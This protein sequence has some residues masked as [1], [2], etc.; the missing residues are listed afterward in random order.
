[1]KHFNTLLVFVLV[2]LVSGIQAQNRFLEEVFDDIT[3]TENVVY[4]ENISIITIPITGSPLKQP[5][6]M[7]I[8]E[9]V[10]DELDERPVILMFH[11][12]NFI[13][14]PD[15]QGTGG[16]I[17]DSTLVNI[18]RRLTR[19]GY[20]VAS[21]DYRKGWN[22]IADQQ[23][24]RV[25][26]L[27]NAAYR[28]VQDARTAIRYVKRSAEEF[29]NPYRFDPE[30]ITLWG[31]GTGGYISLNTTVLDDY[32]KVLI[33][34]FFDEGPDGNPIPMVIQPIHGDIYGTSVGLNPLTGD[35]LSLPNHVGYDSDFHLSV[36]M[37][38]AM[39][40]TSW[41]DPGMIPMI[42]YQVPTDPFAPYVEAV[43]IVPGV[44]LPV[45]EVQ[46]ARLVQQLANQYGNNNVFI[47]ANIMDAFTDAANAN[48]DGLEGLFPF[49]RN[50]NPLDSA[51]WSWWSPDNPNHQ[52]G[53]QTNPDMSFE[54]ANTYADSI[55]GYFAPRAYV[56][57]DL[58]GAVSTNEPFLPEAEIKIMPNPATSSALI[59]TTSQSPIREVT[60]VDINGRIIDAYRN[61]DNQYFTVHRHN[62]TAGV[63]FLHC[64]MDHGVVTKRLIFH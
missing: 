34:K 60:V 40:D 61:V 48:N 17:R 18:A 51:P 43:L 8:Y 15:N 58:E 33:D 13:P 10:D 36:N 39:G 22:P 56:A 9:P 2:L 31:I 4:G 19:M 53:L 55:L 12:G 63:Y 28:G 49:L 52:A 38:G 7:D 23:S 45:V 59:S 46:G 44:N 35:T 27:I 62:K 54:K 25:N 30:R 20:V 47:E 50:D 29:G 6:V 1:M 3:V 26:T 14:H 16:T 32:N 24:E 41:L 11:T 64:R 37:G 57:L 42:S 5:L 21:V